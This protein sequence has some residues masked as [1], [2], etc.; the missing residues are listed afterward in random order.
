MSHTI[1]MLEDDDDDRYLSKAIFDEN[2]SNVAL[3][4]VSKQTDLEDYLQN[5]ASRRSPLPALILLDYHMGALDILRSLKSDLRFKHIPVVILSG[6]VHPDAIKECY[7]LGASSFIQKPSTNAEDKV[8][9][10]IK[11]WFEVAELV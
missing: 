7:A 6:A 9:K 3:E 8:S 11:Y 1:L 5:A 10:F 4:I 2:H